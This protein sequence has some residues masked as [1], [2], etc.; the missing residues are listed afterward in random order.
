M[1]STDTPVRNERPTPTAKLKQGLRAKW[2]S[3]L[4]PRL[5][6]SGTIVLV[7]VIMA[8]FPQLFVW[9]GHGPNEQCDLLLTNQSPTA[10]HWFGRD[11]QGCD[12]YTQV[13]YGARAAITVGIVVS[14]IAFVVSAALGALAGYFGGWVDAVISRVCDMAFGLPFILAA[15][16][17]LQLFEERNLWTVIFALSLFSWPGGVR[18]MRS[19]VLEVKGREF[20]QATKLLG[21]SRTRIVTRHVVPNSITPLLVLQT[22]GV[23]SMISAEAGLTFIGIGLTPPAVS[24]GLQLAAAKD[25]IDEAAHLMV[26]PSIFLAITVL[27]FVLFGEALRDRFDPKGR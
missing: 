21:G 25:Y 6:I 16:V 11:T 4:Q 22:L 14:A 18:Y 17:V 1:T 15:I 20:I 12:Y 2:R 9:F 5:V 3:W 27:G 26:F 19:A 10:G 7:M 13:V 23:G 8:I 24:W